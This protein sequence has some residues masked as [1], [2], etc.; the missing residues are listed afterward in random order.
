[1]EDFKTVKLLLCSLRICISL[2]F[3]MRTAD[4]RKVEQKLKHLNTSALMVE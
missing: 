2:S 3:I 4:T 1:M